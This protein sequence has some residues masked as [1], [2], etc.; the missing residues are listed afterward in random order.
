MCS[1][2]Q[3]G[4]ANAGTHRIPSSFTMCFY[5]QFEFACKDFRWG[6]FKEHCNKEYRR[7]ETCGMKL[8]YE[9]T[10]KPELCTICDK[11]ERKT[12]RYWKFQEKLTKWEA[13]GRL[14][15]LQAT[16]EK[17]RA[18]QEEVRLEIVKLQGDR[19]ERARQLGRSAKSGGHAVTQYAAGYPAAASG[20]TASAGYVNG[21]AYANYSTA[22]YPSTYYQ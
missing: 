1:G 9:V 7:G 19:E 8:V 21:V 11:I 5:E 3:A 18:E 13:E 10:H 6:N 4:L 15:E 20:Q 14:R 16:V 2:T 22:G 17:T 12:R